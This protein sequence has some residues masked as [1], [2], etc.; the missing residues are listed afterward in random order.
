VIRESRNDAAWA[1]VADDERAWIRSLVEWLE[2]NPT[3]TIEEAT[4]A[5]YAIPKR[6]GQ[7]DKE[8]GAAQKR[9]FQIVYALVFG[10]TRGPR[11]GTF[12]AVVPAERYIALLRFT[13]HD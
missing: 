10:A 3:F 8:Q 1:T 12:L 5:V 7:T 9:F 4:E 11:L 2:N 6:E 13:E